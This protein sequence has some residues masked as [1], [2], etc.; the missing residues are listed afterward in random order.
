MLNP[1]LESANVVIGPPRPVNTPEPPVAEKPVKATL[2]EA[3]DMEVNPAP[4]PRNPSSVSVMV[5]SGPPVPVRICSPPDGRSAKN[6]TAPRLLRDA[7]ALRMRSLMSP[8]MSVM[9]VKSRERTLG[10]A[11]TAD[12]SNKLAITSLVRCVRIT[13][14]FRTSRNPRSS[15]GI[16]VMKTCLQRKQLRDGP[17]VLTNRHLTRAQSSCLPRL[18][19]FGAIPPA[20]VTDWRP[21]PDIRQRSVTCGC[22]P[23]APGRN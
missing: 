6:E 13:L 10:F 4:N 18:P 3:F 9:S 21:L 8:P 14:S 1:R 19:R 17:W 5:A 15:A 12:A 2:P 22:V 11:V 16:A 23:V 20:P 7:V